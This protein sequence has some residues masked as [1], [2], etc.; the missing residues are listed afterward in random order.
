MYSNKM[1]LLYQIHYL[2]DIQHSKFIV[3]ICSKCIN[4]VG[5]LLQLSGLLK[6]TT[7]QELVMK[8]DSHSTYLHRKCS[9]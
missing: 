7:K 5:F 3:K 9:L 6:E 2:I 8:F 1:V 4:E